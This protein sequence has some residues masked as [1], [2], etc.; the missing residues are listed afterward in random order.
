M[1]GA[2]CH[3]LACRDRLSRSYRA[4]GPARRRRARQVPEEEFTPASVAL[5]A[6]CVNDPFNRTR[7]VADGFCAVAMF[8]PISLFDVDVVVAFFAAGSQ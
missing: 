5:N 1:S 2:D 8:T 7:P 3:G 4:R 6:H